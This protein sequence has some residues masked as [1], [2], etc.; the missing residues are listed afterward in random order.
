MDG[1]HS[2]RTPTRQNST[3]GDTAFSRAIFEATGERCGKRK[4]KLSDAIIEATAQTENRL[5]LTRNTR[6]FKDSPEII[7][8]TQ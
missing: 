6:D 8:L 2:W 7:F 5:F 3:I 1:N 4:I